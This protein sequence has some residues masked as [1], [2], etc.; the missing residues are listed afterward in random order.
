MNLSHPLVFSALSLAIRA[1]AGQFRKDKVTPYVVHPIAVANSLARKYLPEHSHSLVE[2][3]ALLH[4]VVED[5]KYSFEEI[6]NNLSG[7]D[8]DI[9]SVINTVAVLTHRMNELYP[10][11]IQRVA[12]NEIATMVKIA[13]IEDNLFG[14]G[15]NPREF[16]KLMYMDALK[17]LSKIAK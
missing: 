12:Q 1:H 8:G 16:K 13:D 3:V 9:I 10:D 7:Y 11:Y 17:V 4:D 15:A 14:I 5:S 6:R 2:A